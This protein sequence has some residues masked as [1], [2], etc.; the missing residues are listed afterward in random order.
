MDHIAR[1]LA[2]LSELSIDEL[3]LVLQFVEILAREKGVA[4]ETEA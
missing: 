3:R 1:L 2:I 4:K